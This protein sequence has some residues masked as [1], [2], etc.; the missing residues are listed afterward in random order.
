MSLTVFSI[1]CV[2]TVKNIKQF[3]CVHTVKMFQY[4]YCGMIPSF[5]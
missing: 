4:S 5:A 1:D 2:H 3:D